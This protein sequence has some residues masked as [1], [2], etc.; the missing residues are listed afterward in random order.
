MY[1]LS[2][3]EGFIA[4]SIELQYVKRTLPLMSF[5]EVS[6]TEK[7]LLKKTCDYSFS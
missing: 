4:I 6:H 5:Y 1:K 3:V 7:A 2:L